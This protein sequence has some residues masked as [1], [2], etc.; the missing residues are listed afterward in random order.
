MGR[1]LGGRGRGRGPA[2]IWNIEL[3]ILTPN[4]DLT[5]NNVFVV[6]VVV[7]A[8]AAAAADDDD[9]N[10]DDAGVSHGWTKTGGGV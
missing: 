6:V 1:S 2:K 7:V 10:V 3:S 8:A 9:V 4:T 5:F